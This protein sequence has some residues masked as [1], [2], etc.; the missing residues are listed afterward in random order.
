MTVGQYSSIT[1]P[2][3]NDSVHETLKSFESCSRP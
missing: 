2:L 1:I 3:L